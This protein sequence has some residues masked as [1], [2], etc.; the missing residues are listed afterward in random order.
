M[1]AIIREYNGPIIGSFDV[2]TSGEIESV[3]KAIDIIEE[4]C[5]HA[6][7]CSGE[8]T[9]DEILEA[10]EIVPDEECR[11]PWGDCEGWEHYA[12]TLDKAFYYG[13]PE[14][15]EES[16]RYARTEC[17]EPNLW[18]TL[19]VEKAGIT[20]WQ[21]LHRRGASKQVAREIAAEILRKNYE[22]LKGWYEDGWSIWGIKCEML[23]EHESCWGFFSNYPDS[24]DDYIE[25]EREGIARQMAHTLEIA[26]IEVTGVPDASDGRTKADFYKER[27]E[28]A[29]EL[30]GYT[31]WATVS[32]IARV[33]RAT[34]S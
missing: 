34:Q 18:L 19:Q 14:G 30:G 24:P 9:F 22:T 26:G 11:T 5:G 31:L 32:E 23:G 10:T 1:K 25:G 8:V 29:K 4:N 28:S 2:E 12:Q 20:T 16:V 3:Q 15:V 13:V 21:D 33:T 6:Y 17:N 27:K 7:E